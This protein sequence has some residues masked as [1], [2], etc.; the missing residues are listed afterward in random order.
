L[1]LDHEQASLRFYHS[2]NSA[3]NNL[4]LPISLHRDTRVSSNYLIS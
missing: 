2:I 3:I 4:L 1:T